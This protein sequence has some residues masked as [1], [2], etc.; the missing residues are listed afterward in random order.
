MT[1]H[2]LFSIPPPM[3]FAQITLKEVNNE[4]LI[5]LVDDY[6]VSVT[7]K[8]IYVVRLDVKERNYE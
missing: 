8:S 6:L 4:I 2:R 1:P 7:E 5:Q 3:S